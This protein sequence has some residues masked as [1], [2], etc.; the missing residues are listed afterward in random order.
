MRSARSC[1]WRDNKIPL[2]TPS[3]WD[4]VPDSTSGFGR[5]FA[6][7]TLTRQ[8]S[9]SQR[10]SSPTRPTDQRHCNSTRA[11]KASSWPCH[12]T[13]RRRKQGTRSADSCPRDSR[14]H[15]CRCFARPRSSPSDKSA[16]P[17]RRHSAPTARL[18]CS[19]NPACT[20]SPRSCPRWRRMMM[21]GTRWPQHLLQG[22][23]SLADTA[24]AS[25]SW[26][27]SDSGS[28]RCSCRLARS[29]PIRRSISPPCK[30]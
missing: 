27:P 8:G 18:Y 22:N 14:R 7:P 13:G 29:D 3:C 11:C 23:T 26:N 25:T 2:V 10:C 6:T 15:A 1:R 17:N 9:R 19:E 4:S 5:A 12:L 21:R 28:R 16:R 24:P 30:A 20:V